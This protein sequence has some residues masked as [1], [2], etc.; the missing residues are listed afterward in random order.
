LWGLVGCDFIR[1]H[2]GSSHFGSRPFTTLK[3]FVGQLFGT[4]PACL[5]CTFKS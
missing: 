2:F 3:P 4:P 1:S 5:H